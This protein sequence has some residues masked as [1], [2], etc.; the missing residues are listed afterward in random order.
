MQTLVKCLAAA[1]I[2]APLFA[3]TAFAQSPGR[4]TDDCILDNC[5]DRLPR[6]G[7]QPAPE[8]AQE[9]PR[10]ERPRQDFDRP[11]GR[12][13]FEDDRG[14]QRG[15]RRNERGGGGE[16]Y[17][18]APGR[19]DF[20][21]LALSWSPSFC[22]SEAGRRSREQCA[23]GA[24]NA[25]VVHGLWPQFER[26]FP[27]WCDDRNPPRYAVEQARGVF[28]EEGLARYQWRKHGSCSGLSPTAYYNLVRQVKA[29]VV[30]PEDLRRPGES[31]RKDP[32][33]IERAFVDANK[34]LRADMI[35]VTCTRGQLEEVRIC[36]SKDGRDF[37]TCPDVERNSCRIGNVSV[38]A[39]R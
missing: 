22:S 35:A 4:N 39:P 19:F 1:A 17:G 18:S 27:S 24:G 14:F 8:R 21:V 38:P 36:I 16:R 15:E 37:R 30:I 3:A 31:L 9:Q 13:R 23:P 25:F 29:K 34:S 33:E 5:R 26:G 2:A 28:P 11:Y 10:Q 32:R 20:Y 6:A 12:D 7:S